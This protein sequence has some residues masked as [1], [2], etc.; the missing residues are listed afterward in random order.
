MVTRHT[1]HKRQRPSSLNLRLEK[2]RLNSLLPSRAIL[3]TNSF[4]NISRA[5][6]YH[7]FLLTILTRSTSKWLG[8]TAWSL[9][10][11]NRCYSHSSPGPLGLSLPANQMDNLNMPHIFLP[12]ATHYFPTTRMFSVPLRYLP[13]S[14]L[15]DHVPIPMP[16]KPFQIPSC[17]WLLT[18][19]SHCHSMYHQLDCIAKHS[20]TSKCKPP[21][22]KGSVQVL[23]TSRILFPCSLQPQLHR[24]YFFLLC[25]QN[26]NCFQIT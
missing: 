14:L 6:A 4:S 20:V 12:I 22:D 5:T 24:R 1:E 9:V 3:H 10:N 26:Q 23:S 17:S 11:T 7:P 21:E 16:L 18:L 15:W 2:K 13:K 19:R 8:K 25:H